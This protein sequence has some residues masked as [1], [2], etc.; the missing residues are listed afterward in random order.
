MGALQLPNRIA[1]APMTRCRA[2][3]ARVVGELQAEYYRQ[4]AGA[5]L[6][7]SEATSVSPQGVGYVNT[8]GIWNDEQQSGWHSVTQAVHAAGGRIFLQL[9]HVGS[10]SHRAFQPN[11]ELPV[12][13]SAVAPQGELMLPDFSQ[14]AFETPRALETHEIAGVVSDFANAAG[15][16]KAAGFD[17]VELHAANSYL[18]DQFLRDGVNRRTDAYGG[19]ARNRARLL[20]ELLEATQGVWGKDRVA[21]RL[22]PLSPWHGM[23]DANPFGTFR[24]VAR[25]LKTR[26]LA[27]LHLI[28]PVTDAAPTAR[29]TPELRREF[30]GPLMVNGGHTGETAAAVLVAGEADLVSFGVPYLANPDLAERIRLG[31]E[32]NPPDPATF[33]GGGEKGYTDYPAFTAKA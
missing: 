13:S 19:S 3:A 24:L 8:P 23:S 27:Y 25:E 18:I 16:A 30:G 11:G 15:R 17:G 28:E 2:N 6:L 9:W 22:S 20:L 7:I 12:S 31:A 21:V 10:I 5:G 29:I 4:R 33:Y 32:L 1:M 14:A 26:H